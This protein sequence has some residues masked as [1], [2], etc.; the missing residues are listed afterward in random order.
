MSDKVFV[1]GFY[2]N[3]PREGAPD[4]VKGSVSIKGDVFVKWLREN[5]NDTGYANIDIKVSKGGKYYSELNN[6]Q[7]KKSTGTDDIPF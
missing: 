6:W 2:F 1:D 4:F 7:P 3:P 5:I